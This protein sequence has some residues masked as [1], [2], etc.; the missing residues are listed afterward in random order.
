MSKSGIPV[1]FFN[2]CRKFKHAAEYGRGA[3]FD[4]NSEGIQ[5]GQA[6]NL[7]QGDICVVAT[8]TIDGCVTFDW[9][10]FHRESKNLT[11]GFRVLFGKKLKSESIAK[12][13]AV[14][15]RTYRPFFNV[16]GHFNRQSTIQP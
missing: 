6:N 13:K 1:L 14:R 10:A 7:H 3:F 8:P 12:A 11:N 16:N 9:Y 15:H 2:N 4:L 5:A